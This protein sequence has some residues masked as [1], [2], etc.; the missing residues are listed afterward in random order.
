MM[1]HIQEKSHVHLYL[2]L[3]IGSCFSMHYRVMECAGSL[4]STRGDFWR[5]NLLMLSAGTIGILSTL[6]Y[7]ECDRTSACYG[8]KA[9]L[10]IIIYD[11]H[12]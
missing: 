4:E 5:S 11:I 6:T 9:F 2:L 8:I 12:L 7:T 1:L 3:T 10:V